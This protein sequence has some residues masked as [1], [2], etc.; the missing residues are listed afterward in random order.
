MA[1]IYSYPQETNPQAADLILG[2]STVTENG[3]Q[4]NVTRSYTIQTLTDYIK[5]LGGIGVESITFD[6]PLT[7]GTI[8]K[9]GTVTIPQSGATSDGYLSQADWNTFNNNGPV[10]TGSQYSFPNIIPGDSILIRNSELTEGF[11]DPEGDLIF[12]NQFWTDY[13]YMFF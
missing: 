7:G 8:T 6:A 12:T 13:G 2:T 5:S 10:L 9:T 1:I 4:T 3:K 11:T